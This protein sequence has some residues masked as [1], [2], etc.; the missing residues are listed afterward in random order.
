MG[1]FDLCRRWCRDVDWTSVFPI[2]SPFRDFAYTIHILRHACS[3]LSVCV[4][5]CI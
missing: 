2:A 5:V 3:T 1:L 4:F